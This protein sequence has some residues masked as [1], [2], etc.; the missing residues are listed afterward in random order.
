MAYFSKTNA[1][2]FELLSVLENRL[3]KTSLAL[4]DLHPIGAE[5]GRS[6]FEQGFIY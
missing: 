1:I 4:S 2:E 3:I 6:F 5:L